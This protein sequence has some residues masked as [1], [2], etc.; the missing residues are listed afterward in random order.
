MTD[1][2]NMLAGH[3]FVPEARGI[4]EQRRAALEAKLA[5]A[6]PNGSEAARLRAELATERAQP[7]NRRP[8]AHERWRDAEHDRVRGE[9]GDL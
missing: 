3:R 2:E 1:P 7:Q 9:R 6:A 8:T 4:H 5:S